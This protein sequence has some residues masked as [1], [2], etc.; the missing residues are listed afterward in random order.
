MTT[1][2]VKADGSGDFTT[3]NAAVNSASLAVSDIIEI[4][5]S[6]TYTEEVLRTTSPVRADITIRAGTGYSPI[7]DGNSQALAIGIEAYTGWI[8]SGL[9]IREFDDYAISGQGSNRVFYVRDCVIHDIGGVSGRGAIYRLK[10]G[11]I[12]ERC[13]IYDITVA[14]GNGIHGATQAITVRNCLIYN[15][16][17]IGISATGAGLVE[18]C[19]LDNCGTDGGAAYSIKATGGTVRYCIVYGNS[20]ISVGGIRAAT[21]SYNDSYGHT[22]NYYDGVGTGDLETDP[23]FTNRAGD[24]YTLS[25]TSPCIAASVGSSVA[26]DLE[27][28]SRQWDYDHKVDGVY[29]ANHE[30]M[31]CHER[32]EAK[33]LGVVTADINKV[34]GQSG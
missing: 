29:T 6:S 20:N 32:Y 10:T 31:G 1:H 12:V 13:K 15:I 9:E 17:D 27:N 25:P 8:I 7:L 24:D 26:D 18:H 2:V 33:V 5:D 28:R 4:Q 14:G 22:T 19:T 23:L 21:H 11:S 34:M 3:I 30:E 16:A